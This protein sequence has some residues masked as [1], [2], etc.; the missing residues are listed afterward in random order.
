MGRKPDLAVR[1]RILTEA[2][3]VLHLRGF[4]A[5]GMEEIAR[6]CKMTKAN[7]FHHYGS[8]EDL[9]LA[10]LDA[11]MADYR[12]RR[13][14]PLC[15][16]GDTIEGVGT[17]FSDARRLFEGN[18]CKAGCFVANFALEMADINEHFR[19]RASVFF[20]EWTDGIEGCLSKAKAEGRFAK[21]LE[22]RAAAEAIVSLYE[23]AIML[24]RTHRDS[25]IFDRVGKVARSIL[26][27]HEVVKTEV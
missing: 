2:E 1:E 19:K 8:K 22:P 12:C 14:D 25:T 11:K 23:G 26:K 16:C 15:G 17:M 20:K 27:Q 6:C 13:V 21:T 10:V 7:L 9:A 24:A 5:T 18:G 3:H 4:H